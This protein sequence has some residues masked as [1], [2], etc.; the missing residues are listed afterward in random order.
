MCVYIFFPILA[1]SVLQI[2]GKLK[3]CAWQDLHWNE[4]REEKRLS[5]VLQNSYSEFILHCYQVSRY[6]L[7]SKWNTGSL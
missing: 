5:S 2:L 4:I 7:S 1:D 3:H 6:L